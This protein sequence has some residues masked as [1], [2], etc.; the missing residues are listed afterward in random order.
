M[1][2]QGGHFV[3]LDNAPGFYSAVLYACHFLPGLAVKHFPEGVIQVP[4]PNNSL[5]T[6]EC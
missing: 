4:H 2:I 1:L 3:F 6:G 5:D